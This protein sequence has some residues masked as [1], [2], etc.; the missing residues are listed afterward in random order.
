MKKNFT[1]ALLCCLCFNASAQLQKGQYQLGGTIG[2]STQKQDTADL[3]NSFVNINP[4]FGKFYKNNRLVGV[5]LY[6]SYSKTDNFYEYKSSLVGAG[7]FLRQYIPLGKSFYFFAEEGFNVK[8]AKSETKQSNI[9]SDEKSTSATIYFYPAIAY[10][11][12]KVVQVELSLPNLASLSYTNKKNKNYNGNTYV[13]TKTN[14]F[15]LESGVQGFPLGSLGLG[16]R[17]ML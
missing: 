17:F 13:D 9:L 6:Y 11:V 8:S 12:S 3:K 15:A 5:N 10:S 7:V 4:A 1:I 14:S 2:F 16:I